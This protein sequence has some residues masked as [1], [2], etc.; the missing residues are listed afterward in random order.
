MLS[1]CRC[2]WMP[3]YSWDMSGRKLHQ[4]SWLVWMQMPCWSQAEWNYSEM[5]RWVSQLRL[6]CLIDDCESKNN[7]TSFWILKNLITIIIIFIWK[8]SHNLRAVLYWFVYLMVLIWEKP[9]SILHLLYYL[10]FYFVMR[11]GIIQPF[12]VFLNKVVFHFTYEII[13]KIKTR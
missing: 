13:L 10:S 12:I 5:W 11:M 2:W 7:I 8:W 4:Y 3:S 9:I 6:T 1:S